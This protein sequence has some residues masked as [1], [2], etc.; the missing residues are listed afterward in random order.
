MKGQALPG[1]SLT[2]LFALQALLRPYVHYIPTEV[3]KLHAHVST[4]GTFHTAVGQSV[5]LTHSF[6][7]L[8][9]SLIS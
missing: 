3:H 2:C 5:C 9:P 8:N 1:Q 6:D 4:L 7:L